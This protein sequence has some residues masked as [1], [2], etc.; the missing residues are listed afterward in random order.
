MVQKVIPPRVNPEI[1]R[2]EIQQ[3]YTEVAIEP[4]KG[5]HFHTGY[6][7]AAKDVADVTALCTRFGIPLPDD[8]GRRGGVS[9]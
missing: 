7:L 6:Q 2:A 9:A 4:E 3:K 1:L 5:F 8:F